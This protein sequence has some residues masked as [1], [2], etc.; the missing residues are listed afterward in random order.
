MKRKIKEMLIIC[1]QL[2]VCYLITSKK[3]RKYIIALIVSIDFIFILSRKMYNKHKSNYN[4]SLLH[5]FKR[6]YEKLIL[7]R[8]TNISMKKNKNYLNLQNYCRNFY[9]DILMIERYY[10][11]LRKGGEIVLNIEN[12]KSY[13]SNETISIFDASL[14][15]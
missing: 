13:L 12:D 8:I 5:N 15:H 7:G 14:L 4:I 3:S 9:T 10:S 6:D 2:I 1:L 11:F